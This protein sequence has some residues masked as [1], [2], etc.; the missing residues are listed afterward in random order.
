MYIGLSVVFFWVLMS[1][2]WFFKGN[3]LM[4]WVYDLV[5]I[6]MTKV[7]YAEVLVLLPGGARVLDVG[8]GTATALVHSKELIKQNNITVVGIDY[9]KAYVDKAKEV[10]ADARLA[11]LIKVHCISIYEPKLRSLFTG[12]ARFD[13]AY[14]SGSL[15]LMPDPAAALKCAAT[16]LSDDGLI[17]VTQTFQNRS[18]PLTE[19]VKPLLRKFTS[20]DFGRVIY[21]TEVQAIAAKANMKI[22]RDVPINGSINNAN[23][24]ATL[25][26]LK[27]GKRL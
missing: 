26:V 2:V 13:A 1:M 24:T 22:I 8:I 14:F 9:E 10:V 21:K 23:Q 18:S 20:I 15:T 4:A 16:M 19:R 12:A 5:I 11:E 7:W 25:L 17:Y 6:R 3:S 27:P